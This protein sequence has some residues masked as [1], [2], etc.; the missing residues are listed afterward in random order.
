MVVSIEYIFTIF[1]K[2]F[3]SSYG[4]SKLS[5]KKINFFI[6]T[7]F[8]KKNNNNSYD[9]RSYKPINLIKGHY[10]VLKRKQFFLLQLL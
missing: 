5:V 2:Y 3:S 10:K 8:E 4:V 1:Y 9:R 6:N 7:N